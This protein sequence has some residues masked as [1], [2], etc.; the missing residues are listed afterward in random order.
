[1]LVQASGTAHQK[2]SGYIA[3]GYQGSVHCNVVAVDEDFGS[4]DALRSIKDKIEVNRYM[5]IDIW[6]SKK[7]KT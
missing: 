5:D 6:D 2:L 3:R 1:M 7:K 4:A